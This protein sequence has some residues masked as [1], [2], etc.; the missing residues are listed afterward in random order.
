MT[1][2]FRRIREW[3]NVARL[4]AR[5]AS[6]LGF[7]RFL[8][9]VVILGDRVSPSVWTRRMRTCRA[10]PIY[11][12]ENRRCRGPGTMSHLGCGCYTPWTALAPAPYIGVVQHPTRLPDGGTALRGA[13]I[14]G[15]WGYVHTAG[16][17]GWPD[18]APA[19]L[20]EFMPM[21]WRCR[22][23]GRNVEAD[24]CACTES[25]SPWEPIQ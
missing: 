21:K 2:R 24:R 16:R 9:S 15:C 14:A 12:R 5:R 22:R 11:D 4:E 19:S 25:P 1:R 6:P 10:C 17:F 7:L 3:A 13:Y 23:C 8:W 20:E 18:A